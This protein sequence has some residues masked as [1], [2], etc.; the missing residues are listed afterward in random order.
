MAPQNAK[1]WQGQIQCLCGVG[2]SSQR[3]D[4]VSSPQ[5]MNDGSQADLAL[6]LC[7]E[8]L[9]VSRAMWPNTDGDKQNTQRSNQL[10][11]D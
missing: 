1:G 10:S 5:Q 2:L 7:A 4:D 6:A 8:A 3:E 9:W 11:H